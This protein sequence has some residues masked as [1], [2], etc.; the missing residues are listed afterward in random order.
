MN[1]DEALSIKK[2]A[3]IH[4]LRIKQALEDIEN[5]FPLN[6]N[7]VE[8]LQKQ[9]ILC[10]EMLT[11]RFSKLQ[12]FLG[13][14]VFDV[15]FEV[16]GENI[17]DWTPIDKLNKL[18]KYG[19]IENANI[20]RQIRKSRNFLTHEYPEQ[21]SIISESLNAIYSFVPILLDINTKIFEKI[22]NDI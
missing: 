6:A 19:L 1:K 20:W 4:V 15:F 10:I 5:L 8:N 16:E 11:S 17:T 22:F 3:D 21:F 7:K 12:D 9:E 14:V 13:N 18:E 2:I